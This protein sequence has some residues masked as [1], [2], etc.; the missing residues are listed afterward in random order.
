MA[1]PEE[2]HV[3]PGE[4]LLGTDSHTC[5][6]GAFGQFATGIGNTDGRPSSGHRQTV[7]QGAA[8]MK[9]F[10]NLAR[11]GNGRPAR[12]VR[13]PA[14]RNGKRPE[15]NG[16]HRQ[17]GACR[18]SVRRVAGRHRPVACATPDLKIPRVIPR[19][20]QRRDFPL[21]QLG[22]EPLQSDVGKTD[23]RH[24]AAQKPRATGGNGQR[25]KPSNKHRA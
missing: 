22:R 1:L 20:G 2:G 5:T 23:R 24:R 14:E 25:C 15:G 6:A 13:R 11:G 7:A 8:D 9:F 18:H 4:I 17:R 16:L 10:F 12:L 19:A 21:G 3:R